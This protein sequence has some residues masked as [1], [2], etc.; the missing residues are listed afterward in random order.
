MIDD[1]IQVMKNETIIESIDIDQIQQQLNT[2]ISNDNQ[3]YKK[4]D[5]V[6]INSDMLLWCK[7][8]ESHTSVWFI[9]H[10]TVPNFDFHLDIIS[11]GGNLPGIISGNGWA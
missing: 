8:F 11:A 6:T 7:T 2:L 3:L 4:L 10:N 9:M 5:I 1:N